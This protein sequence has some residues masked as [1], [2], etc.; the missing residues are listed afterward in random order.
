M[1][2]YRFM[3][4]SQNLFNSW[5]RTDRSRK[6]LAK[7][8][9][10][11]RAFS[12]GKPR[13]TMRKAYIYTF[14]PIF[15]VF[16]AI[17]GIF[18][19]P[20]SQI[21]FWD[22]PDLGRLSGT[23]INDHPKKPPKT[24]VNPW[25]SIR[26]LGPDF[27]VFGS[28]IPGFRDFRIWSGFWFFLSNGAIVPGFGKSRKTRK[29]GVFEKRPKLAIFHF[30]GFW[31]KMAKN[32]LL[33][34]PLAGCTNENP[35]GPRGHFFAVLVLVVGGVQS[36]GNFFLRFFPG[37]FDVSG[38]GFSILGVDI[39]PGGGGGGEKTRFF[40]FFPVPREKCPRIGHDPRSRII[41]A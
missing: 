28:G 18:Q 9:N 7:N 1:I 27:G 8:K 29:M 10:L 34:A 20:L 14:I 5:P 16:L 13:K 22:F 21:W 2:I 30:S 40:G 23:Y 19:I 4:S 15:R 24:W 25:F 6:P 26:I 11:K 12:I 17:F 33:I 38:P 35:R 37:F 31:P 32:G 3:F 36:G 39:I 41:C